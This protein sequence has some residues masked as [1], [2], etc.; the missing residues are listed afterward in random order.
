[1]ELPNVF[2]HL[3]YT[4]S[5]IATSFLVSVCRNP[6]F[7]MLSARAR[8]RSGTSGNVVHGA[9][10]ICVDGDGRKTVFWLLSMLQRVSA[11]ADK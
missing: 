7:W 4:V 9:P 6:L 1:M 8:T 3:L 5:A 11:E 10:L 2:A